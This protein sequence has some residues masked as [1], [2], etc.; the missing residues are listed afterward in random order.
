MATRGNGDASGTNRA[1]PVNEEPPPPPPPA[2]KDEPPPAW[3]E[4]DALTAGGSP[5]PEPP[6]GE[7]SGA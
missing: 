4:M 3:L 1:G 5:R 6:A 2:M 7:D